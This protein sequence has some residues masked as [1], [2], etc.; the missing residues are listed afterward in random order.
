MPKTR[1][2]LLQYLRERAREIRVK[3]IQLISKG[4]VGHP[5]ATLSSADIFAALYFHFLK[6]D[7]ANPKWEERD[8]FVLSKGHGV[9]PLY[10]ALALRGFYPWEELYTTYGRVSSR[11]QGHPDAQKTPGIEVSAG[12][13]GQGLSVAVGMALAARYDGKTHRVFCFMGDGEC[14][15]GQIWEAAMAASHYRLNNLVGIV[16]R[17]KIQAKGFTHDIMELEPFADKW[18]A[19]G[20]HVI[21][22]DG[23]DMAAI[24]DA[25][26]DATHIHNINRP[27]VVIAHTVKGRGVSWMENTH[28][29]HTHAPNA[30]ECERA[31]RELM[32]ADEEGYRWRK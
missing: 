18:R 16:D 29:W 22:M 7:P 12:S 8:R 19:F 14:D 24:L 4:K 21:E 26:Y 10:V 31:V 13:L 15:E 5:G 25:L 17:N 11:F 23:H 30:E 6:L 2:E 9:P 1:E 28:E 27:V 20:W 32:T 3:G